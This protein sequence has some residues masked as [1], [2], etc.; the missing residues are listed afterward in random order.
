MIETLHFRGVADDLSQRNVQLSA[1]NLR[2]QGTTTTGGSHSKVNTFS[3]K[4]TVSRIS[5]TRKRQAKPK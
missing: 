1:F 2:F 4:A 3:N 5:A